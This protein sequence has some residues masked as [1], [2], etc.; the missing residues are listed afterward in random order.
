MRSILLVVLL[1]SCFLAAPISAQTFA[2]LGDSLTDEYVGN[3]GNLGSTDLAALNWVQLLVQLR[4]MDFGSYEGDSTVRGEPR[5][6]GYEHVWAR[7]GGTVNPVIFAD[8]TTQA[9]GILP[10]VGGGDIDYLFIGIGSNDYYFRELGSGSMDLMDPGYQT[11][12]QALLDTMESVILSLQAA[13]SAQII[14]SAVPLGT[15]GGTSPDTI[16]AIQHYNGE[17]ATLLGTLGVTFFNQW[18]W[19]LDLAR[20]DVNGDLH[21][22]GYV[23][24][25]GSSAT[26]AQ[27]I[28]SGSPNAGPCKS[29]GDCATPAYVLNAIADDGLHPN[30]VMQ[31][32]L[33]N[34][35]LTVLNPFLG[36]PIPLLSD[37]EVLEAAAPGT[38]MVEVPMLA[39]GPLLVLAAGLAGLGALGLR[40]RIG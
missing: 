14:V 37:D 25:D 5:L 35:F 8:L 15:A 11:F 20:I 17:L 31:G 36:S 24:P 2:A 9:T 19:T 4:G 3:P 26:L 33:A 23:I 12:E 40:R 21:Y 38:A 6:E 32:L 28:P 30:T 39:P 16:L 18:E 27:T 22:G 34:E 7:S 13:G 29:T 10:A 1:G